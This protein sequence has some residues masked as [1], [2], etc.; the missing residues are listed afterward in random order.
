MK[1]IPCPLNPLL[2]PP[3]SLLPAVT[4][5]SHQRTDTAV[6]PSD[7]MPSSFGFQGITDSAP[8][9]GFLRSLYW[10]LLSSLTRASATPG[11]A[12]TSS[13]VRTTPS[14]SRLDL[15]HS[16][17]FKYTFTYVTWNHPGHLAFVHFLHPAPTASP[18]S[19]L[20]DGF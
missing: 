1:C 18:L 2:S 6:T 16:S 14:F 19:H 7:E 20:Q 9:S 17:G 12:Q 8:D 11:S 5:L 3:H 13:N 15:I 10:F 4:S